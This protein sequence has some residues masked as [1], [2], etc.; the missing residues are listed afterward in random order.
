MSV[1]RSKLPDNLVLARDAVS[2]CLY[3]YRRVGWRTNH[4]LEQVSASSGVSFNRC[5]M[6][7]YNQAVKLFDSKDRHHTIMGVCAARKWLAG[8]LR[9]VADEIEAETALIEGAENQRHVREWAIG[10]C[11]RLN[12][13]SPKRVA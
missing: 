7:F 6:L 12:A 2:R 11:A 5:E 8:W 1:S 3:Y 4:A 13:S 9:A 10:E